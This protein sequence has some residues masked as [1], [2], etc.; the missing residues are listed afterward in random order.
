MSETAVSLQPSDSSPDRSAHLML[1]PEPRARL[2]I[3]QQLQAA[4]WLI[5]DNGQQNLGAGPGVVVREFQTSTGPADYA[6]FVDR[7]LVGVVEAK[8]EGSLLGEVAEQTVRYLSS[9]TKFVQRAAEQLPFGDEANGDEVRFCDWRDP[10]PRSRNVFSFHRP[11]T[12]RGWLADLY[13]LRARLQHL[14]F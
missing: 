11:E 9:S 14:P 10:Q 12:L 13:P 3:D 4:G 8:P 7:K 6:L 1:T 2:R 5:Y